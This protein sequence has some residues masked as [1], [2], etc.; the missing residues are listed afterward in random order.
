MAG[1]IARKIRRHDVWRP[2]T[3]DIAVD[4]GHR[5]LQVVDVF[6]VPAANERVVNGDT[7][8]RVCLG[9]FRQRQIIFSSNLAYDGNPVARWS[10]GSTGGVGPVIGDRLLLSR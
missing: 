4:V 5:T 9:G 3:I 10:A 6:R 8:T 7:D 1:G 2:I